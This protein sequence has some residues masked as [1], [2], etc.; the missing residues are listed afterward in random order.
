LPP[1]AFKEFAER[2]ERATFSEEK[3]FPLGLPLQKNFRY[4]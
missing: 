2:P 3:D 1:K 4:F